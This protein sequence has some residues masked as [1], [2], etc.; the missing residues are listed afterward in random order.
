[1]S[2]TSARK[3]RE[4]E[5]A[6][7]YIGAGGGQRPGAGQGVRATTGPR[8]PPGPSGA[9]PFPGCCRNALEQL[10]A[11][12]IPSPPAAR[13]RGV[14]PLRRQLRVPSPWGC[15]VGHPCPRHE[16]STQAPTGTR[17]TR[18]HPARPERGPVLASWHH[19]GAAD[20]GLSEPPV[21]GRGCT[22]VPT[23]GHQPGGALCPS[24][25]HH[26][27]LSSTSTCPPVSPAP[28]GAPPTLCRMMGQH[29]AMVA[30]SS[31]HTG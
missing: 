6:T 11:A 15:G 16:V 3:F 20:S 21:I 8:S 5:D 18:G 10:P 23:L 29:K 22:G 12:Q 24:L 27:V 17:G 26:H 4:R 30:V 13:A 7:I 9:P 25:T 28:M 31:E 19:P 14:H 1:M 2:A